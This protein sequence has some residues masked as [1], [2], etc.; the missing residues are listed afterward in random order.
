[1]REHRRCGALDAKAPGGVPRGVPWADPRRTI[2]TMYAA[3][4]RERLRSDLIA[5]ARDDPRV[6]AAAITGSAAVG[7]EDRWS[8]ID[9]AFSVQT[10]AE[11]PDT[12]ADW[13][14]RM[15]ERYGALDHLDVAAGAWIYRVF[16]LPSTLQVDLAFAP[17]DEF[18]AS[19]PTFRLLFGSAAEQTH[20]PPPAPQQLIGWGWLYALHARSCISRGKRW[21]AEYMISGIRDQVLALAC[22]RHGLPAVQ[23]RG[24]DALPGEVTAPLEAAL[25]RRLATDELTR[26]MRAAVEGLLAEI[27]AI[28]AT[29]ATRLQ[30]VLMELAATA[31][32]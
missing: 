24:M 11:I 13:T 32:S 6:V 1:V 17:A 22:L 30:N 8:D 4:E 12:I 21:Q 2:R 19:A 3:A 15:N 28:D 31:T 9:L 7:R 23:G 26:A 18:G 27:R 10:A 5:M 29:L 16:L 14:A 20:V 25:V